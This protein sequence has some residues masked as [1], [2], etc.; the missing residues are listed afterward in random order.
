MNRMK[1]EKQR[2]INNIFLYLYINKYKPSLSPFPSEGELRKIELSL[3][4]VT[5]FYQNP[6]APLKNVLGTVSSRSATFNKTQFFPARKVVFSPIKQRVRLFNVFYRPNTAAP[7]RLNC[8]QAQRAAHRAQ[9]QVPPLS[10]IDRGTTER[11]RPA[12]CKAVAGKPSHLR[13]LPR[14]HQPQGR[15]KG[16]VAQSLRHYLYKDLLSLESVRRP[17]LLG[18]L[19]TALALQ[20]TSEVSYNELAQTVGTSPQIRNFRGQGDFARKRRN[21]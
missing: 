11:A 4:P 10:Y 2:I 21:L 13:F 17:M 1:S 5:T 15:R 14:H 8:K 16:T 20:V 6:P 12:G 18:K 3:S 9:V 19:L 7:L